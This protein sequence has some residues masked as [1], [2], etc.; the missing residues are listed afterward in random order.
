[1]AFRKCMFKKYGNFRT[2]L[3]RNGRGLIGNEDTEFGERLM[4]AGE[5]L[6]YVPS[7]LIYHPPPPERLTKSY[8]R[9]YWFSYGRSVARQ[10]GERPPLWI[11]PLR[12]LRQFKR[13][14]QWMFSVNRRWFLSPHGRFY[15][16]V[17]ALQTVGE[18]VESYRQSFQRRSHKPGASQGS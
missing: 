6:C 14:L 5:R 12:Y 7:A 10:A 1:M 8:F 18:I 13:R 4:A 17:H 9:A 3:G 2:D 11:I 15:C 16:E